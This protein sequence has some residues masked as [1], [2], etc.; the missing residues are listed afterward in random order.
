MLNNEQINQEQCFQEQIDK[1]IEDKKSAEAIVLDAQSII[2]EANAK[3]A[4]GEA[5][6]SEIGSMR[7]GDDIITTKAS[8]CGIICFLVIAGISLYVYHKYKTKNS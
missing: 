2:E 8:G 6:L 5:K 1:A 4:D 3:I 7:N